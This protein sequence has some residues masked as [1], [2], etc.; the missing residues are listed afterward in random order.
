MASHHRTLNFVLD[1][2][3]KGKFIQQSPSGSFQFGQNG[4]VLRKNV[5]QTLKFGRVD[6]IIVK[7]EK[8][9]YKFIKKGHCAIQIPAQHE[10]T[11]Y[12]ANPPKV[13]RNESNF[14]HLWELDK[15]EQAT[16]SAPVA[17]HN[18]LRERRKF[19]KQCMYNPR[20]IE[21]AEIIPKH[22]PE[23]WLKARLEDFEDLELEEIELES[24]KLMDDNFEERN[25]RLLYSKLDVDAGIIA[26]L[27]DSVR[28][29]QFL[30]KTSRAALP[31][32]IAPISLGILVRDENQSKILDLARYVE[33]LLK[34]KH[35]EIIRNNC[36][37]TLDD[38]GVP[39]IIEIDKECLIE[40]VLKLRDRETAWTEQIHLAHIVPRMVKIFQDRE[41]PNTYQI[42]KK[43]YNLV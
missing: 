9:A 12:M 36:H 37:E 43:K 17:F 22:E 20:Q 33:L 3:T 29:R 42:V 23:A 14:L 5:I 6:Q 8:E 38:F 1:K 26:M 24:L 16:S 21:G 34:H 2:L 40:G 4:Q 10:E 19:W 13:K 30:P 32:K 31:S 18:F 15:S 41:E 27:L 7:D 35:I 39:Y 25:W 11:V 28:K